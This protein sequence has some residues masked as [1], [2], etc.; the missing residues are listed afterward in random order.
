MD[1]NNHGLENVFLL[2][3]AYFGCLMLNFRGASLALSNSP[4]VV[5][6][7]FHGEPNTGLGRMIGSIG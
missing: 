4:G 5:S 7:D 6:G 1:T 2:K 3:C